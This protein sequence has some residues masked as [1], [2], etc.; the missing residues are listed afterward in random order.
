MAFSKIDLSQEGTRLLT[1]REPWNERRQLVDQLYHWFGNAL[2]ETKQRH[3]E[4]FARHVSQENLNGKIT[5]GDNYKGFAYVL[6]DYPN[7]FSKDKILAARNLI[8]LGN[9]FHCTLHVRGELVH[10]VLKSI[11]SLPESRFENVFVYDGNDEWQ[12]HIDENWKPLTNL[13]SNSLKTLT[14]NNWIKLGSIIDI[15]NPDTWNEQLETIYQN[16]AL[17]LR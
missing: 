13:D 1:Q 6:V 4:L 10:K 14:E 16:W 5:R 15:N 12:H 9:G 7:Q 8:W 3:H 2:A 11:A 17:L